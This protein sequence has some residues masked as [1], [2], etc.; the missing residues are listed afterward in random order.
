[1]RTEGSSNVGS[2]APDRKECSRMLGK[3]DGADLGSAAR[4][5]IWPELTDCGHL[6]SATRSVTLCWWLGIGH[7]GSI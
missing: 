1:M 3:T 4:V 6:S 2:G 7:N 5:C